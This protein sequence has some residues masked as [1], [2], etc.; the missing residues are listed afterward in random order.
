MSPDWV[1]QVLGFWFCELSPKSWF[2][3]NDAVDRQI[4]ERFLSVYA[5]LV[6]RADLDE[7]LAIANS[8]LAAI[9]VLDQFPRNMF[10]GTPR[11]FEGDLKALSI[12]E[13]AVATGLDEKVEAQRRIFIYLPFEHSER[14]EDQDKSVEL[15]TR[16]GDASY[17]DYAHA[18]RDI[19]LRFGRFPHRNAIL[20]RPS[21]PE[22]LVFL[23]TPGSSF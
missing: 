20:G 12:A 8:A 13:R 2:E 22:E 6:E 10:R 5:N 16:L 14:I 3:K 11:S 23:Q 17:L 18:H 7:M 15:F 19:I 9:V 4:R 1:A 21:T